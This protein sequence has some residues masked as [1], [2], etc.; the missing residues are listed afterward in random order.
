MFE[1][2]AQL[3]NGGSRPHRRRTHRRRPHRRRTH[4]RHG[5]AGALTVRNPNVPHHHRVRTARRHPGDENNPHI[6]K[7]K[8]KKK[9][10]SKKKGAKKSKGLR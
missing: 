5:R 7:K 8:S 4:R 3:L 2:L 6:K 9:K 1:A 10:S